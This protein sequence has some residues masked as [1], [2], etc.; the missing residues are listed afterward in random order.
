M[1]IFTILN[2]S[3][4]GILQLNKINKNVLNHGKILLH[5]DLVLLGLLFSVE[6]IISSTKIKNANNTVNTIDFLG[7]L[8]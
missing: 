6:S 1:G 3:L 7:N 2:Y 8:L 4:S 5:E